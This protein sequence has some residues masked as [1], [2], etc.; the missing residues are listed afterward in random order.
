MI[1]TTVLL[2][3]SI[4]GLDLKNGD[5][6]VDGTL[7]SGGHAEY[8]LKT[9]NEKGIKI[10]VIGLDRDQGA[11]NRS[12][13]R[14]GDKPNISYVLANYKDID[15]TLDELGIPFADKIMLDLGLSSDQFETSGRGF[16][17][18]KDEPL[19]MTFAENSEENTSTAREIINEWAE[20]DLANVIFQY[21]EE[22]YAK[23]IAHEIVKRREEMLFVTTYD[24]VDAIMHATPAGYHHMKIHPATRTFQALRMAVND[25]LGALTE[26]LERGFNRLSPKGRM[27]VISF[28]SIEDRV[29]KRFM[30]EKEK[31]GKANLITKKPIDPTEEEIA[32]NP[33]SRSAK[34]RILEKI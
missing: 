14:L 7:G 32:Q 8:A 13:A 3:E 1:H 22:H 26:G 28:H 15:L 17:F 6:Y 5:V 24:L 27:S 25:E 23:R 9:A 18:R 11:L 20:D 2:K 33:R 19:L 34:L 30:Q 29:V 4:D 10:I 16:S 31:Q 21:G 12:K